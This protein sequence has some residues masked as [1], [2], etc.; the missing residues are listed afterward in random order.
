MSIVRHLEILG[1]VNRYDVWVPH[2]LTEKNLMDPFPSAILCSNAT[3][4]PIFKTNKLGKTIWAIVNH[5]KS[6]LHS[7]KEGD[8]VYLVGLEGHLILRA[9]S[10]QPDSEFGQVL[11]DRLK[12]AIDEK[13]PK[14]AN[15]KDVIFHQDNARPHVFLQT[16]QKL[17]QL[18]WDV[19][20]H[21]PYS[22]DLAPSDYHLFRSLQNSLN[23]KN[24]NSLEVCKNHLD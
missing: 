15:R 18:G 11:L 9:P 5:S 2:D 19:L 8:A 23:R 3:K 17:V 1:Y 12:A 16:R 24:F 22:H 4:T 14:L 7:K 13:C 21:L 20:P 10:A 6:N